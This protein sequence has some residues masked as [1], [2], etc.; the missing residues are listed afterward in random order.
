MLSVGTNG[1]LMK[2]R[3]AIGKSRHLTI[4]TVYPSTLTCSHDVKE[5][6]FDN[7][8]NVIKTTQQIDKLVLLGDSNA[9][10]GRDQ[11]SWVRVLGKHGVDK[12]NNN[13]LLLLRKRCGTQSVHHQLFIQNG[14]QVQDDLDAPKTKTLAHDR[15]YHC[16]PALHR[17]RAGNWRHERS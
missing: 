9:S 14:R 1:C 6:S 4:I 13:G 15:L 12:A 11:N 10:V 17:G 2:L 7:L 5:D 16:A 8:D 3:I